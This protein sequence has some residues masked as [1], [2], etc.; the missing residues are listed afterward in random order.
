MW[1]IGN[2]EPAFPT[3]F[4]ILMDDVCIGN[5]VADRTGFCADAGNGDTDPPIVTD[6]TLGTFPFG[7][8]A[9]FMHL[10]TDEAATCKWSL[11]NEAY[12]DMPNTFATT[13]GTKHKQ[14][15]STLLSGS[16]TRYR[17]CQD[18]ALNASAT[19]A[20][21][22]SVKSDNQPN[23]IEDFEQAG[24][25][26]WFDE[27]W[28]LNTAQF[29]EGAGSISAHWNDG[30]STE[31]SGGCGAPPC[32]AARRYLAPGDVLDITVW[33]RQS[34]GWDSTDRHFFY[35]LTTADVTGSDCDQPSPGDPDCYPGLSS[36]FGTAYLDEFN[37]ELR[38][39]YQDQESPGGGFQSFES[40]TGGQIFVTGDTDQ[41]K[42][43]GVFTFGTPGQHSIECYFDDELV[44]EETGLTLRKDPTQK[45]TQVIWGPSISAGPATGA[46]DIWAD[47]LL[48]WN[49]NALDSVS[50]PSRFEPRDRGTRTGVRN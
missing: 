42:L 18:A 19:V 15:I 50:T 39:M 9:I 48:V 25:P 36:T 34:S 46:E 24:P 16:Y 32:G 11:V 31:A 4:N 43:R 28:S 38:C 12:A 17:A 20:T 30:E 23:I 2:R 8:L 45:W 10:S 6:N 14:E 27:P 37:G 3:S 21:T 40:S 26:A 33:R 29:K 35:G 44:I 5:S 49:R 1:I 41:H 22:W 7:D 47:Y 13:G